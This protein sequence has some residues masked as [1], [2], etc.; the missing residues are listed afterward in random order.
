MARKTPP[1]VMVYE[2]SINVLSSLPDAQAGRIIKAVCSFYL[3][4]KIPKMRSPIEQATTQMII[5]KVIKDAAAYV[6]ICDQ[7]T[8][9]ARRRWHDDTE[10]SA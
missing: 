2:E 1:G 9:N 7:N 5:D 3:T 8:E 4:N 6:R 10:G